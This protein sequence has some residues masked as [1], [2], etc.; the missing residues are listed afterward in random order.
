MLAAAVC[1]L[2]KYTPSAYVR[3]CIGTT[4]H[5]DYTTRLVENFKYTLVMTAVW[6]T[7]CFDVSDLWSSNPLDPSDH[8]MHF[9]AG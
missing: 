3:A 8:E 2:S 4:K 6:L 9:T 5:T 1:L 7:T